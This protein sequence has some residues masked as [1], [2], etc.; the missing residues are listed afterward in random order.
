MRPVYNSPA[1]RRLQSLSTSSGARK[2]R[3]LIAPLG[4]G[5]NK[6]T[7]IPISHVESS[8]SRTSTRILRRRRRRKLGIAVPSTSATE[9][10]ADA[11]GQV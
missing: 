11:M 3:T 10:D 5:N 6:V 9:A 8:I 2:S 7:Y 1:L 4:K